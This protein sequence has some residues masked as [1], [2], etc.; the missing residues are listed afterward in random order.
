[1]CDC[2]YREQFDVNAKKGFLKI[3]FYINCFECNETK[4]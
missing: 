3:D 2:T 1:M 4:P